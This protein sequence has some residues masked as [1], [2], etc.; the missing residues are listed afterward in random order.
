MRPVFLW[1]ASQ[2]A[3]RHACH[4][5][6][7]RRRDCSR[8]PPTPPHKR[9]RIR[10][11]MTSSTTEVALSSTSGSLIPPQH[12]SQ[13]RPD[14]VRLPLHGLDPHSQL[15]LSSISSRLPSP[16]C[17]LSCSALQLPVS[18]LL[19]PRL[20]SVVPS[21]LLSNPVANGRTTDLPG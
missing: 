7:G 13:Y 9:F 2:G 5:T 1:C 19:W 6:L 17:D 12:P 11:F 10:R 4:T 16:T 3:M 20:T 15:V 14:T 8:R 21:R 18:N